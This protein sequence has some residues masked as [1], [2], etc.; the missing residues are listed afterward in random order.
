MKG[1]QP[2]TERTIRKEW[3][4]FLRPP[5]RSQRPTYDELKAKYGPNW[6]MRLP[7]RTT[8][9]PGYYGDKINGNDDQ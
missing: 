9:K 3:G 1:K 5:S 2:T 7:G 6:G 4:Q 8:D